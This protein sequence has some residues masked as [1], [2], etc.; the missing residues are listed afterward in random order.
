M[1]ESVLDVDERLLNLRCLTSFA[2]KTSQE[3]GDDK[4]G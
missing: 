2:R 1:E 3:H 4:G